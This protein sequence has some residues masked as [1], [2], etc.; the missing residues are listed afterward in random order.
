MNSQSSCKFLRHGVSLCIGYFQCTMNYKSSQRQRLSGAVAQSPVRVPQKVS[1]GNAQVR[2]L[3]LSI[4]ECVQYV[5]V[6]GADA[7]AN[8]K[9]T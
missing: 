4:V 7:F 5:D 1:W 9:W 3:N 6:F 8:L 2:P